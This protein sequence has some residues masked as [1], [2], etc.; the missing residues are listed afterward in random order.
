MRTKYLLFILTIVLFSNCSKYGYVKLKYPTN[1]NVVLPDNIKRIA[2]VNRSLPSKGSKDNV[3]E[4]ILTGEVAGSDKL[5]SD[6]CLKAVYDRFNGYKDIEIRFPAKTRLTGTGSRVTPDILDWKIVKDICDSTDSDVLLVLEMFDSNSDIVLS[7]V[8][9]Q[10]N[11]VLA[12]STNVTPPP[13]QIRMNVVCYWRMY[14]PRTKSIIDQFQSTNYLTFNTTGIVNIP[15]PEA[16]PQ[17]AYAAG[18]HYVYRFFPGYYYVKRDMYKRGKGQF[19][20]QF[21]VGFRKSEVANWE[22]AYQVWLDIADKSSGK[23]AGRACLNLAVACE[24]L[25]RTKEALSWAKKSYEDYGNKLGRDYANKLK[26]RI[27]IE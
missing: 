25:G 6:E 14:D 23:N 8:T 11:S 3:I 4:A 19:K 26:Y 5:A 17:T 15:P 10:I 2:I 9:N 22:G 20:Q 16:L 24:V 21:L 1:P 7:A 18:E 13:N 27:R 12:G